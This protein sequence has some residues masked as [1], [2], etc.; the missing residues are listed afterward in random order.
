MEKETADIVLFFGRFHP[1]MLHVPIGFLTIAFLIEVVSRFH[2]FKEYRPVVGFILFL[3]AASAVITSLLGYMLAQSGGYQG[4]LLLVHQWSGIGVS[5]LSAL[6]FALY[7]QLKRKPS[8]RTD[9]S[10]LAV[11]ASMVIFLAVAGHFGGSLTHGSDYLTRYMPDSLRRIAGLPPRENKERRIITN[12][13]EAVVYADIV[14]PILDAYCSS[15]HNES[16][17][18]GELMM[19]TPKD[20]M[21]GGENGPAFVP[22]NAI[23]SA[24][25]QRMQLPEDHEDHMPPEGKKQISDDELQL[26]IWWVNE[27]ATFDKKVTELNIP[28]DV[29]SILNTLVDPDAN[30][31]EVEILLSSDVLPASEATVQQLLKQGVS[32]A[33]LSNEIHWLQAQ[34]APNQPGDSIIKGF[35][36]VSEQLTW[37]NLGGT[38]VT[39]E[40]LAAI[41]TFKFLTRLHLGN[42]QITDE[43]LEYLKE[44]PYLEMLNIYGTRVSDEGIRHL[45]SLKNLKKLYVWKTQVTEEGALRLEKALPGLEVNLGTGGNVKTKSPAQNDSGLAKY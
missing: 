30:K 34:A 3:G 33:P 2:R 5:L 39:D 36:K 37:L 26:L 43:G 19:H 35:V 28:G 31:T 38:S 27:G 10:Y 24:M 45:S 17:Q 15:C 32:V 22:G 4:D 13:N 14:D 1:L 16:K 8:R 6:A 18:K 11:M 25:I 12:L 44:L 7:V 29:D 40:G 9:K 21:K 20:L 23:E 42:T 41:G